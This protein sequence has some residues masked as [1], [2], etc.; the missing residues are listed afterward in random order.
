MIRLALAL[1]SVFA[2]A[3]VGPAGASAQ[4]L[5]VSSQKDPAPGGDGI[6]GLVQ[7]ADGGGET[8][9]NGAGGSAI[10]GTGGGP[11]VYTSSGGGVIRRLSGNSYVNVAT[12]VG[13]GIR[14]MTVTG[15]GLVVANGNK[16]Q[17][18]Q[19]NGTLSDVPHGTLTG[20]EGPWISI[21]TEPNGLLLG[22]AFRGGEGRLY[23][24]NLA[25]GAVDIQDFS[26]ATSPTLN[27]CV[28]LE[29]PC[30]KP[31]VPFAGS[32]SADGQGGIWIAGAGTATGTIPDSQSSQLY[33]APNNSFSFTSIDSMYTRP[34]VSA[35]GSGGA[36]VSSTDNAASP[37]FGDVYR[38]TSSTNNTGN[39]ATGDLADSYLATLAVDRCYT[40][41]SVSPPV[42]T[43]NP[44]GGGGGGGGTN[45][46][47]ATSPLTTAPTK[48]VKL[49]SKGLN[50]KLKCAVACSVSISGSLAFGKA[51]K[52][53]AAASNKIK[54][55]KTTLKAGKSKTVVL[56]LSKA[57]RKRV[58]RALRR[59]RKVVAKLKIVVKA[60]GLKTV[61]RRPKLR[62]K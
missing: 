13:T 54:T 46:G 1:S 55:A 22:W 36:Y 38:W 44:S 9:R 19:S 34:H 40:F 8:L 30:T 12:G 17:Y 47:T 35:T 43:G 51:K 57:Q 50:V 53:T 4:A 15:R 6:T 42:V 23:E 10:A 58:K 62:V 5:Y 41:C 45:T 29:N 27:N 25:S 39:I 16:L 60:P 21:T 18:V 28:P 26:H 52:A 7:L 31:P 33:Y 37:Y 24:L 48:S 32:I 61:T 59:K 14:S 3:C 49:G 20:A 56:K 11:L 2:F